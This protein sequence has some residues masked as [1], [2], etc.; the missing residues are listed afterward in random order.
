MLKV[1]DIKESKSGKSDIIVLTSERKEAT[2]L[3]TQLIRKFYNMN[4][5]KGTAT[6]K[7]DQELDIELEAFDIRESV[8]DN[9]TTSLWL[10][11]R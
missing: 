5:E 8:M 2:P 11:W 3:G 9:G 6:V 1:Y 7:V 10:E 4:V